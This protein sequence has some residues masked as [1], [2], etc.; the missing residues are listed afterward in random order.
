MTG[1]IQFVVD[2]WGWVVGKLGVIGTATVIAATLLGAIATFLARQL[3][4]ER[5]RLAVILILALIGNIFFWTAFEQAGSSMNFFAANDTD[6]HIFG[7]EFPSTWY[8]SVN[9]LAIIICAPFFAF[10]WIWLAKRKRNPSTPM[11]FAIGLWLLGL[12]F[13]AMVLG[14]IDARDGLAGPHWLLITYIVYTW[15]ELCLSPVGLSM[16]TKL[17]PKRLQSLMMGIWFMSLALSNLLAGLIAAWSTQFVPDDDGVIHRTFVIEGLPGF[18]LLLVIFP[19]GAGVFIALISPI[20]RKM[21][22]GIH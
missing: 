20:L 6:L 18:Y 9:A 14:A 11:K 15:G 3:P 17:A 21:M 16:V 4:G 10:L 13:I 1:N 5:S 7:F 2:G 22:K 12:S 19:I 8:Q